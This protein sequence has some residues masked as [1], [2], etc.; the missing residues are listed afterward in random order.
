[1]KRFSAKLTPSPSM[2]VA[3]IALVVA[4]SGSAYAAVTINGK[5][6]KKGTVA[7]K[8]IKNGTIIKA[9]LSKKLSVTGPQ[10]PQGVPGAAAATNV[11]T[12]SFV[13]AGVGNTFYADRD[14]Q[15]AAG[16]R[17]VG[18]GASWVDAG[19]GNELSATI[20]SSAPSTGSGNPAADG[21]V[22]T[23]WTAAGRNEAGANRDFRVYAVCA[24]P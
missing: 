11:V 8:Q 19:G 22:P 23:G 20:S 12:H 16:E 21:S 6:I 14:V 9:D 17:L 7:S 18:G 13:E 4:L 2:V 24:K 15:C 1:M 5:N 3:M 10:G